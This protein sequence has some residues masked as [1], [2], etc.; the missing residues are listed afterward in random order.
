M[1]GAPVSL[2]TKELFEAYLSMDSPSQVAGILSV[3][4][5]MADRKRASL[6]V[7]TKLYSNFIGVGV[8]QRISCPSDEVVL[9]FVLLRDTTKTNPKRN[10]GG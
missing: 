4:P 9:C 6:T 8:V 1:E 7:C 5:L 2:E 10:V 3:P